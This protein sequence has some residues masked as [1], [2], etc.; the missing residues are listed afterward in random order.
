MRFIYNSKDV[1]CT[2]E[3][4]CLPVSRENVSAAERQAGSAA[5]DGLLRQRTQ[6]GKVIPNCAGKSRDP[7]LPAIVIL[8]GE[9]Q[10]CCPGQTSAFH[11]I[12]IQS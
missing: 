4:L 8:R 5:T 11:N 7:T 2:F 10:D 6:P 12:Q 9:R 1:L 3:L